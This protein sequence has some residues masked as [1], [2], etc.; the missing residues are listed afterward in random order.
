MTQTIQR[1]LRFR[2]AGANK[3]LNF[4][5]RIEPFCVERQGNLCADRTRDLASVPDLSTGQASC[6]G[7]G[8]LPC[9]FVPVQLSTGE[10][11][12]LSEAGVVL[13]LSAEE[14]PPS[15]SSAL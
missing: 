11:H 12:N 1:W 10:S 15:G 13:A 4:I 3:A 9:V 8:D 6:S 5:L 14:A 2:V 7:S